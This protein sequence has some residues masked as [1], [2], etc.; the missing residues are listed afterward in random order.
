M[1]MLNIVGMQLTNL[2]A[3]NEYITDVIIAVIVYLSAFSLVIR[4]MLVNIRK[5]KELKKAA[6]TTAPVPPERGAAAGRAG[7]NA[8]GCGRGAFDG[9][10][11]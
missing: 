5:R 9:C 11:W 6:V 8:A 7:G 1:A 4:M 10:R 3:Y 2:T